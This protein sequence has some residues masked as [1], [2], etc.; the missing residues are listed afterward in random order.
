MNI[1]E[2]KNIFENEDTHFYYVGTHNA[3][4]EFLNKYLIRKTGNIILDAGCGTGALMKKLNKFGEVYG[5]DV[6]DEAL[7]FAKRNGLKRVKKASVMDIP[8]KENTFDAVVSID[9]LY[10]KQV[11]DDLKALR[12]FRRVLKPSGLLIIKNPAHNWL[13]GSHDVIIHT[14]HR[15]SKNEFRQKLQKVDLQIVKLS[16]INIIFFPLAIIKRL[17]ESVLRV[18]PKSD[19][20][21]LPTSVNKLLI[22]AYSFEAKF[23]LRNAI[24]FGLS[25]FVIAKKPINT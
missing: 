22:D 25:L 1:S 21:P 19:V 12:E 23:L 10:H 3:V 11:K 7:K 2:Y 8:F 5:I 15:Y 18:T 17:L 4:I 20:R 14:K 6:S 13:R 24:P 16:Y 9:V